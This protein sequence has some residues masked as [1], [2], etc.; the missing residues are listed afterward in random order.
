VEK[1]T[2]WIIGFVASLIIGVFLVFVAIEVVAG[3][4][5]IRSEMIL[6]F[7]ESFDV[8]ILVFDIGFLFVD[9][10]FLWVFW[11]NIAEDEQR[12]K[13]NQTQHSQH[14]HVPYDI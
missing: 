3:P 11:S 9:A 5:L 10:F 2:K 1:D 4:I 7:I 6:S 14:F 8:S 13:L 12:K